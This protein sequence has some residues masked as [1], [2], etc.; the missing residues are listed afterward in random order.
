[1]FRLLRTTTPVDDITPSIEEVTRVTEML[2]RTAPG[3][4]YESVLAKRAGQLHARFGSSVYETLAAIDA[5][6]RAAD[7]P[8]ASTDITCAAVDAWARDVLL[9]ASD[10]C[11]EPLTGL[12][13]AENLHAYVEQ[14]DQK[15]HHVLVAEVLIDERDQRARGALQWLEAE[16]SLALVHAVLGRGVHACSPWARLGARRLGTA[17]D[18]FPGTADVVGDAVIDARRWLGRWRHDLDVAAWIEPV[19]GEPRARGLL[20]RDLAM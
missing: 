19:P 3:G 9:L 5:A 8:V 2:A 14:S 16:L 1:M 4:T 18:V 11:G 7:R 15:R 17:V 13:S 12:T 20:M 6:F 10:D